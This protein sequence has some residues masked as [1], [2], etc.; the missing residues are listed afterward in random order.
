MLIHIKLADGVVA[1]CT[2]APQRG[3][4]K[5][6]QHCDVTIVKSENARNGSM[7]CNGLNNE[8]P[9]CSKVHQG[10]TIPDVSPKF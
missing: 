7:G 9:L 8:H 5:D 10:S 4:L 1:V 6:I 2:E 3:V